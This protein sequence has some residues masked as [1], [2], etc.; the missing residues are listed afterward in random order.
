M[1]EALTAAAALAPA[2]PAAPAAP[3]LPGIAPAAAPAAPAAP[4]AAAPVAA[5]AEPPALAL[6]AKDA[7]AAEWSKF[8]QG[9][10]APKDATGYQLPVPEGADGAFAKAAAGW[11]AEVGLLPQQAQALAEKWNAYSAEQATLEATR[12]GEADKLELA[13][14]HTE[15]VKQESALKTEWGPNHE[16]NLNLAKQAIGQFLKPVAGDNWGDVVAA[17]EQKVGYANTIK[18][19]HAVGRGLGTGQ[20]RGV[21]GAAAPGQADANMTAGERLV[22]AMANAAKS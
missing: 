15:N 6:P 21:G 20:I 19:F 12:K 17:I 5:P 11:M 13:R 1:S 18:F 2:A 22:L 7:P 10:G 3:T 14:M 4:A 8:F 9:I 16:A